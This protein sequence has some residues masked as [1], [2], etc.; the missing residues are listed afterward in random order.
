[1]PRDEATEIRDSQIVAMLCAASEEGA[2][3][4]LQVHGP[5]VKWL[6]K[7]R[8][9]DVLAEPDLAAALNE[10]AFKAFRAIRT[11]DES[12]GTLGAWFWQIAA[13]TAR[14]ILRGEIRHAHGDLAYDPYGPSRPPTSLA[15]EDDPAADEMLQGLRD[16]IEA[17]PDLQRKIIQADLASGDVASAAWLAERYGT[18][19]ASIYVSRGK[20]HEN[21]RKTLL[22]RGH[23]QDGKV[24]P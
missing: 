3:L 24:I 22:K 11:F 7:D 17:L 12:K 15:D 16:A 13:N 8:F 19:P 1:M 4:L 20:A 5:R 21:L 10:A 14:N 23:S 18:T 9:G 2:R 6:L